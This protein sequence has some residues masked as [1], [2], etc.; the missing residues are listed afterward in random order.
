MWVLLPVGFFLLT[1]CFHWGAHKSSNLGPLI[2]AG[3]LRFAPPRNQ[4]RSTRRRTRLLQRVRAGESVDLGERISDPREI[5]KRR[6][7]DREEFCSC[8]L[9]READVGECDRVAVAIAAGSSVF[10]VRFE[11]G[12]R[13]GM[14]MLAPFDAGRLIELS[15]GFRMSKSCV[16]ARDAR[17]RARVRGLAQI[18]ACDSHPLIVPRVREER[19]NACV[20]ST[21]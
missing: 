16:A 19:F 14:P 5:R 17:G 21:G 8:P 11:R 4:L 12:Q 18:V 9:A 7:V 2:T 6:G 20:A 10:Q 15:L 3:Q 13:G 1:N